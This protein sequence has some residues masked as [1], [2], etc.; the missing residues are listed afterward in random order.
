[1]KGTVIKGTPAKKPTEL[2]L[3]LSDATSEE[4]TLKVSP[5]L[6]GEAVAG[7]QIDF[8]ATGESYVA[9]P[10]HLVL[11]GSPDKI[12]NWPASRR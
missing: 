4:V 5:A 1:L 10:F 8:E 9:N 3:A 7:L 6:T 2:V 11:T 12:E